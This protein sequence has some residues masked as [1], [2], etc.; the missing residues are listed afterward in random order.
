MGGVGALH[1]SSIPPGPPRQL[2]PSAGPGTSGA[3]PK[4]CGCR[5]HPVAPRG[6]PAVMGTATACSNRPRSSAV[7]CWAVPCRRRWGTSQTCATRLPLTPRP[8]PAPCLAARP[9]LW[10]AA[11]GMRCTAYHIRLTYVSCTWHMHS[12]P[13]STDCTEPP[14]ARYVMC[15]DVHIAPTLCGTLQPTVS[16]TLCSVPYPA[17][18]T[19]LSCAAPCT[20][21]RAWHQAQHPG[22]HPPILH[23]YRGW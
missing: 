16:S 18:A 6:Y 15:R 19:A 4:S 9:Q 20:L 14:N 1:A 3:E 11:L 21:Y 13:P 23:G 17:L 12:V 2:T 22:L 10:S 5:A 7:P 8:A